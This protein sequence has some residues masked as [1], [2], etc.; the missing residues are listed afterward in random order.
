[1][2]FSEPRRLYANGLG[3]S[4]ECVHADLYRPRES[5]R[6]SQHGIEEQIVE[7]YYSYAFTDSTKVTFDYQLSLVPATTPRLRRRRS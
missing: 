6:L 2:R 4:H 1:M 3:N 7:A 5:Q